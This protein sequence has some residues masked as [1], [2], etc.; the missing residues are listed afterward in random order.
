MV[1]SATAH[2]KT[3]V[4]NCLSANLSDVAQCESSTSEAVDANGLA[5]EQEVVQR[6]GAHFVN[7]TPLMCTSTVCPVIVGN[8]LVYRDDNH[9]STSYPTWLAPLLAAEVTETIRAVAGPPGPSYAAPSSV[10]QKAHTRALMGMSIRQK[11]HLRV[12]GSGVSL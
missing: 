11:G 6:A 2:P 5:A 3:D 10:V 12:V 7:L 1:L 9:L 8:L 4:P